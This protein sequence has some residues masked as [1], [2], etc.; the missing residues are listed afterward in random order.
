MFISHVGSCPVVWRSL[1]VR[2]ISSAVCR[3]SKSAYF[4]EGK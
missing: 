2:I 4:G 3:I 1:R